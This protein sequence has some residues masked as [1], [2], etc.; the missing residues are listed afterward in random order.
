MSELLNA[1]GTLFTFL[2]TQMGNFANFFVSNILGQIIL[3][4]VVFSLIITLL[5]HIIHKVRGE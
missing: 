5:T 4:C 2:F 1:L 3:G